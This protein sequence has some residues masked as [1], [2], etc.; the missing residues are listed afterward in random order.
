MDR[1][2]LCIGFRID[3]NWE[4]LETGLKIDMK[5]DTEFVSIHL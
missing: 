4:A 5:I 3:W 2:K 1:Y